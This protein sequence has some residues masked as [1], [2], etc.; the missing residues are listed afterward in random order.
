MLLRLI[1]A[2]SPQRL[3]NLPVVSPSTTRWLPQ[4]MESAMEGI[5][6]ARP[7]AASKGRR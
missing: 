2:G 7:T 3:R 6:T 1:E 4:R 5:A